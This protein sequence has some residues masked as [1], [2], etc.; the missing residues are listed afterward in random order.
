MIMLMERYTREEK[1][2]YLKLMMSST[3]RLNRFNDTFNH[4]NYIPIAIPSTDHLTYQNVT[5]TIFSI[6]LLILAIICIQ[7]FFLKKNNK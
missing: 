3:L 2:G 1:K 4:I 6:V 7:C 5:W